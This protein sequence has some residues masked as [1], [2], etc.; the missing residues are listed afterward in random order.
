MF[1]FTSGLHTWMCSSSFS[2]FLFTYRISITFFATIVVGYFCTHFLL[3]VTSIN[4]LVSSESLNSN[5]VIAF[6]Y[7][8]KKALPSWQMKDEFLYRDSMNNSW[9][10]HKKELGERMDRV[11]SLFCGREGNRG[12]P[13]FK[14]RS[15]K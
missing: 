12:R 13:S 2:Y 7:C 3:L 14:E 15:K 8:K 5:V 11:K 10:D 6:K 9:Y 4:D 1:L